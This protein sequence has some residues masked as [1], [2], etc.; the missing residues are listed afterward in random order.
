MNTYKN[1]TETTHEKKFNDLYMN[2]QK[3]EGVKENPNNTIWNLTTR[4]LSNEEYQVLCY[5][6]NHI[7]RAKNSLRA[8]AFSLIDLDIYQVFKHKK[9]LE[10][11]KNLCKELVIL[12]PDKGN[13]IVLIGTNDYYTTTLPSHTENVHS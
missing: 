1:K 11:I 9:K 7:E 12:K 13:G 8:L 5:G 3:E 2:K 6:L 10:V 4:V